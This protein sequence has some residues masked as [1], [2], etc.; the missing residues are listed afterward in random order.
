MISP[1]NTGVKNECRVA[2]TLF[3]EKG[4]IYKHYNV[5]CSIKMQGIDEESAKLYCITVL[6][7]FIKQLKETK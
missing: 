5:K 6:E 1:F 4:E 3:D 2:C 7:K